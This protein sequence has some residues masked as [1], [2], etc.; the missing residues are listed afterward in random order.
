MYN[1]PMPR[2][3]TLLVGICLVLASCK[4]MDA[5]E[6]NVPIPGHKWES[7]FKPLINF[8]ITDT[9]S[10]YNVY[11]VIRHKNAYEFN[12][13]WLR[14]TVQQPA[15][16]AQ[17]SLQYDLKLANDETG[18][19]GKGMDDIF[20]HRILIQPRTRFNRSGQYSFKLEHIMR[21]DPLLHI[22]NVGLRVEK[23]PG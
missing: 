13:I 19:L 22:M 4:P 18:W 8:D 7:S 14:G 11:I 2:Y 6:K 1:N 5:F 3:L 23:T 16:T 9:T 20:E 17:K 10:L 12:N 21:Q 15:D